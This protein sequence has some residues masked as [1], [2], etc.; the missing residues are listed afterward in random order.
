MRWRHLTFED[1]LNINRRIFDK[2]SNNSL[3][4]FNRSS[5]SRAAHYA[6]FASLFA[7]F[8]HPGHFYSGNLENILESIPL[9]YSGSEQTKN[10]VFVSNDKLNILHVASELFDTGGHTRALLRWIE[11]TN[12]IHNNALVLTRQNNLP[13]YVRHEVA[14]L[15]IKYVSLMGN[16]FDLFARSS[17]LRNLSNTWADYVILHIHPDDVVP[18]LA[19]SE[20]TDVPVLLFNHADHV[21]WLGS[22]VSDS[23]LS[24]R[25]SGLQLA[26]RRRNTVENRLLPLPMIVS[27][28]KIDLNAKE[29]LGLVGKKVVLTIA[30]DYKFKAIESY[31]Y[32]S[33]FI[34][35]LERRPDIV[36][37]VVGAEPSGNLKL[38]KSS[39]PERVMLVPSTPYIDLYKSAADVYMDSFPLT[40]LT[41]CLDAALSRL[42]IVSVKNSLIP[43]I[44]SDDPAFVNFSDNWTDIERL[45]ETL[46]FLL[47]NKDLRQEVGYKM[48]ESVIQNHTGS[49][50]NERLETTLKFSH[51]STRTKKDNEFI[52]TEEVYDKFLA[53]LSGTPSTKFFSGKV[54]ENTIGFLNKHNLLN[55]AVKIENLKRMVVEYQN[56]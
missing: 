20:A 5:Y 30:S 16:G 3:Y 19:Y 21:F 41:S 54:Y 51:R 52:D 56:K 44:N 9:F 35:F 53:L 31:N 7:W 8:N 4:E 37:V 29:R 17:R 24:I 26:S 13:K 46:N 6:H 27:E 47:D 42:P 38:L 39:F 2:L 25:E 1:K 28:T 23:V 33:F 10:N 36:L 12:T 18:V 11:N 50:W 55:T 45:A 15:G 49:S 34:R 14:R 43:I 40:S 48:R 32:T 22:S